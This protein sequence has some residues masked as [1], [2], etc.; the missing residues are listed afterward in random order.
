[1]YYSFKPK[2]TNIA[3]QL[4]ALAWAPYWR[5]EGGEVREAWE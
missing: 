2:K 1:M 5:S 3:V 4:V